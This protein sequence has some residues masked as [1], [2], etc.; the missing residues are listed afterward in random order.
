MAIEMA[1]KMD[2]TKRTIERTVVSL[3]KSLIERIGSNTSG[4]GIK[5]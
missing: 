5:I 1:I 3:K 4:S 2:V